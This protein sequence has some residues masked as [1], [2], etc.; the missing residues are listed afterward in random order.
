M[1]K[2]LLA[3]LLSISLFRIFAASGIGYGKT[4]QEALNNSRQELIQNF[5]VNVSSITYI[6]DIENG[7]SSTSNSMTNL[8]LQTT[9]FDLLG[10]EEIVEPLKDGTYKA[11]TTIDDSSTSLYQARISDLVSTINA[12]NK[13]ISDSSDK[14][15][16]KAN[17]LR[18][19]TALKEFELY[20]TVLL[21][22]SPKTNVPT[23]SV[24][25]GAVEAEYQS[26][27]TME[28]NS[29]STTIYD[30]QQQQ[31]L[32]I[33]TLNGQEELKK[34]QA[35]LE[36]NKRQQE[37]MAKAA[38]ADFKAQREQQNQEWQAMTASLIESF[39]KQTVD[40]SEASSISDMI[41]RI[42]ANRKT[43]NTIIKETG[44]ALRQITGQ[45][46]IEFNDIKREVNNRPYTQGE[47]FNGQVTPYAK[48]GREKEVKNRQAAA[49]V[50]YKEQSNA[51]YSEAFSRLSYISNTTQDHIDE[52]SNKSYSLSSR[53]AEVTTTIDY[54]VPQ[55]NAWT[56]TANITI[57]N[58]TFKLYFTIPYRNW[59][60]RAHVEVGDANYYNYLTEAND[61]TEI[62][63]QSSLYY[64]V[65]F[66]FNVEADASRSVYVID[67]TGY[68]I[69]R[70][71]SNAAIYS[72]KIK[73]SESIS[74]T[75]SLS[76]VNFKVANDT[77]INYTDFNFE[78]TDINK[79]AEEKDPK[80]IA[81]DNSYNP[82]IPKPVELPKSTNTTVNIANDNKNTL[83]TD[84]NKIDNSKSNSTSIKP[85][86]DTSRFKTDLI[87]T[88]SGLVNA[89][90]N[91][92]SDLD[93]SAG[94][95]LY[96]DSEIKNAFIIGELSYS[97][98]LNEEFFNPGTFNIGA[99]FAYIAPLSS[100][101]YPFASIKGGYSIRVWKSDLEMEEASVLSGPYAQLDL[102]FN[103][104]T[105]NS[106][107][108][109]QVAASAAFH[110]FSI[111]YGASIGLI[112]DL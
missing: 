50:K 47:M 20:R 19:I 68:S 104:V 32:G 25:R 76:V 11:T 55:I 35:K 56:G 99:G 3:L 87:I 94:A 111:R 92:L 44:N 49:E 31:V 22:I 12:V 89:F 17:Y 39:N 28:M 8:S 78:R 69:K 108:G 90:N 58:N 83:S 73:Y 27:L 98:L 93:I 33:L 103:F 84:T 67:F 97:H 110:L 4:E 66:N 91:N 101:F 7:K 10:K 62:L 82:F 80:A 36:E 106:K 79:S 41:N 61:W 2:I 100:Y 64:E 86:A 81:F 95:M 43:F 34:A 30:L 15:T 71:D 46:N 102:G 75:P 57:G 29:T 107:V 1:K 6:E 52:L 53:D 37:E 13:L 88:G 9:S 23:L 40:K 59:T 26:I 63:K 85:K 5:S 77:L 48:E 70:A 42:E 38:E 74:F 21:T 60:G 109:L 65:I 14:T 45:K 16:Q 96:I 18:L 112:I 51:V 24:S 105:P 72:N 54:F